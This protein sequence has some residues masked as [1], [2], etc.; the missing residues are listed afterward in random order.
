[1]TPDDRYEPLGRVLDGRYKIDGHK[2]RFWG[3]KTQANAAAK[4]IG[5]P[6]THVVPVYTRFQRGFAIADTRFG[7]LSHKGYADL[8]QQRRQETVTETAGS[9]Q[10]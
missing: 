4:A 9:G 5:W 2:V 6:L 10:E 3:W 8:L 7:A 1:M